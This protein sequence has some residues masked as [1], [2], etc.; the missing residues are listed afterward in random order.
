[1]HDNSVRYS[2]LTLNHTKRFLLKC[3][4]SSSCQVLMILY[5]VIDEEE[6]RYFS[7]L[8]YATGRGDAT[9]VQGFS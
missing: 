9:G 8:P 1:M 3:S 4:T 5:I 6:N 2:F 7:E